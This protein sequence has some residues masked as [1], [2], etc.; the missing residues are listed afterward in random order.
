MLI[1]VI[2]QFFSIIYFIMV[3]EYRDTTKSNKCY[4]KIFFLDNLLIPNCKCPFH[5]KCYSSNK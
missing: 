1:F 4:S 5:R 3:M 2:C